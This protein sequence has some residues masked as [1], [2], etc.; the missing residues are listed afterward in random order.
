M[1]NLKEAQ[2]LL[3]KWLRHFNIRTKAQIRLVCT[4]LCLLNRIEDK[5]SLLKLLYPLLRM[6]F[7][8]YIG[9]GK[10]QISPA[11]IIFYPRRSIAVGINL[12][13][14]QKIYLKGIP[15]KEDC[16]GTV[17]F[18]LNKQNVQSISEDIG[19]KYQLYDN[20]N[21]LNN[22]PKIKDVV[23]NFEE[24][25]ISLENAFF[26]DAINYRWIKRKMDIG[27]FKILS[28]GNVY[29]LKVK[30]KILKIPSNEQNPEGRPLAD[31]YQ[32]CNERSDLFFYNRRKSVLIVNN[33]NL[34]ILVERVL[35][36]SSLYK[37]DA[38]TTQF[39]YNMCFP[40]IS[41]NMIQQLNRIFNTK[42]KIENG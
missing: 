38:V 18:L 39:N 24:T 25:N 17:R 14:I 11:V 8:E 16:F 35:Y 2:V 5:H 32:A 7:V 1:E 29:Y 26:F 33:I 40:N 37:E 15:Y 31:C 21:L 20:T 6:G 28:N 23:V 30:D 34:P 3:L 19:C 22:F 27:V 42:V 4:N 41:I 9:S 36:L 12:T 13:D 10:Y